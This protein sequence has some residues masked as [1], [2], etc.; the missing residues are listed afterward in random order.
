MK[1]I[2]EF[3]LLP[4]DTY[5]VS[6]NPDCKCPVHIEIP[7]EYEGKA[8][9][10]IGKSGFELKEFSSITLPKHL[11]V[12]KSRAFK[13]CLNLRQIILPTSLL[14]IETEAFA[15][16]KSL[17]GVEFNS[18]LHISANVF[19]GCQSLKHFN[20]C[21]LGCLTNS[22]FKNAKSNP[23]YYAKKVYVNGKQLKTINVYKG[24]NNNTYSYGEFEEVVIKSDAF[25]TDA[26]FG[27]RCKTL[28]LKEKIDDFISDV[29]WRSI[30]VDEII[31]GDHK[32]ALPEINS[33]ILLE[34][35]LLEEENF[36]PF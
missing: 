20:M 13:S 11:K 28:K 32:Y 26:V 18:T 7:D 8:V 34:L 25:N 3:K 10:Q 19:E 16:C 23:L 14:K 4:N 12:I 2:L 1:D 36:L 29:F 9:T 31:F 21:A 24:T 35:G 27:I 5:E 33:D 15:W 6:I 17:V 30:E 22:I